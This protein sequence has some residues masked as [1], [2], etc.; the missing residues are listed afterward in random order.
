MRARSHTTVHEIPNYE[1]ENNEK[2]FQ[3]D[4][5]DT[6]HASPLIKAKKYDSGLPNQSNDSVTCVSICL[7]LHEF[8]ALTL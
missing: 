4:A 7:G 2:I 8:C 5:N 1:A 3:L 6:L